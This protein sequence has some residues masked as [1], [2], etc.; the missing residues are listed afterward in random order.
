MEELRNIV[1]Y[2]E[3][4]YKI[5]KN[6]GNNI[7]YDKSK[8]TTCVSIHKLVWFTLVYTHMHLH[9]IIKIQTLWNLKTKIIA[10]ITFNLIF[11]STTVD[12]H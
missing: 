7:K 1:C 8:K 4:T 9:K 2:Y 11:S 10:T 5:T 12:E 3:N 6:P